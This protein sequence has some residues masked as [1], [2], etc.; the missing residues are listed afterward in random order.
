F[1]G[2]AL[3]ALRLIIYWFPGLMNLRQFE[4]FDPSIYG[5][6]VIQRSLGDL[7]MNSVFFCWFV[8]FTWYKVHHRPSVFLRFSRWVQW[9]AGVVS[10][11]LLIY[12][13]FILSSLIRS[14]VADSK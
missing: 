9:T 2:L 10:V 4:L 14:I 1:L 8:L 3:L 5:A 13:T 11:C 12:S 7:L 6:N